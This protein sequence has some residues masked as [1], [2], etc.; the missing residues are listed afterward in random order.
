MSED[1]DK[2]LSV[3]LELD[4]AERSAMAS[5]LLDSL[6]P[7]EALGEGWDEEIA[8]RLRQIDAGEVELLDGPTVMQHMQD[9]AD[10][11]KK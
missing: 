9:I 5:A 11:F 10:G 4:E 8:E 3:V 6:E 1:F 7:T 2:L